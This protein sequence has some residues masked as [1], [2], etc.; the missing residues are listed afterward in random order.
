MRLTLSR[1]GLI[2]VAIPLLFELLFIGALSYQLKA[3]QM[4]TAKEAEAKVVVFQTNRLFKHI[5]DSSMGLFIYITTRADPAAK[6]YE[7]KVQAIQT[8]LDQ[9]Q[10]LLKNDPGKLQKLQLVEA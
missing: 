6:L 4:E 2:L 1:R 8:S 9:L 3:A 7:K 10:E 5:Y